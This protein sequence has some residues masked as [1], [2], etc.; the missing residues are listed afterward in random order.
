[1]KASERER[2]LYRVKLQRIYL[3]K[4]MGG[5]RQCELRKAWSCFA[6]NVKQGR[7]EEWD[8]RRLLRMAWK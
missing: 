1:M 4:M 3:R 8:R 7:V 6:D 2:G 5:M